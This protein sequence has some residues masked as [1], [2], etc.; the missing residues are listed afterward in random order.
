MRV[1]NN[2]SFFEFRKN[3]QGTVKNLNPKMEKLMT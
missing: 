1:K 3:Q 2:K